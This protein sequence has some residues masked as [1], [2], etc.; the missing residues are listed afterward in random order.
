MSV[1]CGHAKTES[2]RPDI[3]SREPAPDTLLCCQECQDEDRG[4]TER[5]DCGEAR[6]GT[7]KLPEA[8]DQTEGPLAAAR[9]CP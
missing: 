5:D 6:A 7:R 9:E 1:C 4:S 2:L 3:A 8:P